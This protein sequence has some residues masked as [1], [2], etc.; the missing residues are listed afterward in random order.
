[1]I[2]NHKSTSGVVLS[3]VLIFAGCTANPPEPDLREKALTA[4]KDGDGVSAE[5]V[6]RD[7]LDEGAPKS[8]LAPYFG[9]AEILQ[10]N[11]L[12]AHQWLD[13]ENFAPESRTHGLHMLGRLAMMEG[14]LDLANR[15]L[16]QAVRG[17]PQDPE[18]WVD[19][20]RLRYRVGK[21]T[22]AIAASKE[23]LRIGPNNPAALLF[24]GQ[25]VRDAKGMAAALPLL[26][27]G[28]QFAPES[29]LL[30]SEYAA[31]LGELGR[32]QEMLTVLHRLAVR[33]P[34]NQQMFFLQ[35]VLAAR[36]GNYELARTL[37]QRSGDLDRQMPA[38]ILLLG[39]I[40]L[41]NGNYASAAQGFDRLLRMQPSNQRVQFLLARSL[42]LG[43]HN[44][45]LV[46]RFAD[47]ADAPYMAMVVGRAYEE[48][49]QRE[50]AAEFLDRANRPYAMSVRI[51]P[52]DRDVSADDLV[53]IA[54]GPTTVSRIRALLAVGQVDSARSQANAFLQR[55]PESSD[56][57]ALAG[58]VAFAAGD[59]SQATRFYDKAAVVRRPWPLTIR[60]VY[61]LIEQGR[62]PVAAK[63]IADHL[64]GEPNN[65][66]AAALLARWYY[67]GGDKI[68][69][70]SL[71]RHAFQQGLASDP[72][73]SELQAKLA[74]QP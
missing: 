17:H 36:A 31:T 50:K 64:R 18:L 40:D 33:D 66:E 35:A 71:I 58:D 32:A 16:S 70:Q 54:G 52:A 39:V 57:Q 49:G 11:L 48:L 68:H 3:I 30:L 12:E 9:E 29:V 69:S 51:L 60:M 25:L 61:A 23:A 20:G 43:G 62:E 38:A 42:K 47:H 55:F 72:Q 24:R 59:Y 4:L 41:E 74:K 65:A 15:A 7:A 53:S 8:L 28:L 1:M 2:C 56:A 10:G 21:Q 46:A 37:L 14:D 22:G 5:L 63:L 27:R 44:R 45:E 67:L 73:L 13:S 6:L 26:E 34:A 19:L